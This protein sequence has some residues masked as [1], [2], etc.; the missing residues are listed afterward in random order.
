MAKAEI[1]TPIVLAREAPA[2]DGTHHGALRRRRRARFLVLGMARGVHD[3]EAVRGKCAC[4]G[5]GGL[6]QSV[7]AGVWEVL[8][9]AVEYDP[10]DAGLVGRRP[11]RPAQ[12]PLALPIAIVSR[13]ENNSRTMFL[14]PS[15][16]VA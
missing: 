4:N 15:I 10:D 3:D 9:E 13:H 6:F 8:P 2:Y 16:G 5:A 12:I 14:P 11:R 1:E 7:R